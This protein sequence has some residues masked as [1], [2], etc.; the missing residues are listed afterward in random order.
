M[1]HCLFQL[2]VTLNFSPS[3]LDEYLPLHFILSLIMLIVTGSG[4]GRDL[5]LLQQLEKAEI[6]LL[7]ISGPSIGL[8]G[9]Q[10]QNVD[11][12]ELVSRRV[13]WLLGHKVSDL[14]SPGGPLPFPHRSTR[15]S[16]GAA[17]CPV[18]L[19]SIPR[20]STLRTPR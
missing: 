10:V 9:S 19:R 13:G 14:P 11:G 8:L 16:G 12:K 6:L 7:C 2:G 20:K 17:W 4:E 3:T 5:A 1:I 15:W 18:I